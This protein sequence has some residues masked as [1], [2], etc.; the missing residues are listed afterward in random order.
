MF[1]NPFVDLGYTVDKCLG[2]PMIAPPVETA[3]SPPEAVSKPTQHMIPRPRI[4]GTTG[5]VLM[6]H[7]G[8]LSGVGMAIGSGPLDQSKAYFEIHITSDACGLSVGAV[9]RHPSSVMAESSCNFEQ[10]ANSISMAVPHISQGDVVGVVINI[11]D[12][13]PSVTV[14]V[15]DVELRSVTAMVRGDLWPA[16]ELSAGTASVVFERSALKY[17]TSPHFASRG[18]EPVMLA[19]NI[20]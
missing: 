4:I 20:L 13:P 16:L 14:Y 5:S 7:S 12:F 15:N 18:V 11:A 2:M 9:G 17:I 1:L 3:A 6:T 8:S 19:R 10:I